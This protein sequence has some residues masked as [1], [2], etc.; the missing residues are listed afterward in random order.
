MRIHV[1]SDLHLVFEDFTPPQVEADVVVLA[2]NIGSAERGFRWAAKTFAGREVIYVLGESEIGNK[3]GPKL[4]K[5][6]A[7]GHDFGLHVLEKNSI[8]INGVRFLGATMETN[9]RWLPSD[10]LVWRTVGAE[11]KQIIQSKGFRQLRHRDRRVRHRMIVET[12]N[13]LRQAVGNGNRNTIIVTSG[14]PISRSLPPE[15]REE[16][17]HHEYSIERDEIFAACQ[18]PVWIHGQTY[19]NV[20]YKIGTT[21]VVSNQRGYPRDPAPGFRPG[22]VVEV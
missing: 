19:F 9:F 7:I 15:L 14:A 20:D 8:E 22:L 21:R 6:T 3:S 5:L 13:W 10:K 4:E 12:M 2:G 16:W 17:L 18:V 11:F 1:L